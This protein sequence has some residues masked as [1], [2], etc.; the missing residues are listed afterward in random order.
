MNDRNDERDDEQGGFD[1][2]HEIVELLID[3]IRQDPYPST[4]MMDLVEELL[5]PEDL[6]DYAR[7]L[8]QKIQRDA[9]PSIDMMCRL[10][11]LA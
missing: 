3:K 5:T 7:V 9:F 1:A 6:P 10:R 2:R 11:D 4:T 8:M